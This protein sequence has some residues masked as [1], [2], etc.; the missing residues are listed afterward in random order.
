[1]TDRERE[2]LDGASK[3]LTYVSIAEKLD[4]QTE[5]VKTHFKNIYFKLGVNTKS[6][7]ISLSISNSWI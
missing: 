5:T 3:G 2:V 7:A 4:I 6:E 1:M